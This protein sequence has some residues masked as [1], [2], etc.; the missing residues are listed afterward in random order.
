MNLQAKDKKTQKNTKKNTREFYMEVRNK[1]DLRIIGSIYLS[2]IDDVMNKID[3]NPQITRLIIT[4]GGGEVRSNIKLAHVLKDKKIAIEVVDYCLSSCFNY[5][6]LA[7]PERT[8]SPHS[9]LGFHGIATTSF[10]FVYRISKTARETFKAE[11]VFYNSIG[12]KIKT[13]KTFHKKVN[14]MTKGV[15][16]DMFAIGEKFFKKNNITVK[17]PWYAQSQK[18]LDKTLE[19][20]NDKIEKRRKKPH[21]TWKM[22]GEFS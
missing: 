12:I 3:N 16:A 15:D 17:S 20:I 22:I 13:W 7:S 4:S 14:K 2:N 19:E 5:L 6:F 1:T 8:I 21:K 18:Q 9:V 11:K 10:P